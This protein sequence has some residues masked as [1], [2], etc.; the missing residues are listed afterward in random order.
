M[1]HFLRTLIMRNYL[2]KVVVDLLWRI[3]HLNVAHH[4][5]RSSVHLHISCSVKDWNDRQRFQ[6][7]TGPCWKYLLQQKKLLSALIS[8]R[9]DCPNQEG[10]QC[11]TTSWSSKRNSWNQS[12]STCQCVW[13]STKAAE[14]PFVLNWNI[15]VMNCEGQPRVLHLHK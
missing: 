7:K 10:W 2:S 8:E 14:T 15:C 1:T 4:M 12:G 9:W 5:S 13:E 11:N 3:P 6:T